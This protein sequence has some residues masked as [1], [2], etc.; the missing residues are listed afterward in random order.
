ML[1]LAAG[2]QDVQ[3]ES[4]RVRVRAELARDRHDAQRRLRSLQQPQYLLP[5]TG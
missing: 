1:D 4:D 5:P 2:D 3:V